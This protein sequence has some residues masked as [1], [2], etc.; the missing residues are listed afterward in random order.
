MITIATSGDELSIQLS[1]Y[2][3]KASNLGS[4]MAVLPS[5][6]NLFITKFALAFSPDFNKMRRMFPSALADHLK[7]L[8]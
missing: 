6:T 5:S 3:L 4:F 7:I 1:I 8:L 2:R